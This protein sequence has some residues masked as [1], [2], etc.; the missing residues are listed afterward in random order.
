MKLSEELTEL[1]G[2][3]QEIDKEIS[4][5]AKHRSVKGWFM[6]IGVG[7]ERLRDEVA[8]LEKANLLEVPLRDGTRPVESTRSG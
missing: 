5:A 2:R 6:V 1:S 3:L 7:L 8:A 4:R